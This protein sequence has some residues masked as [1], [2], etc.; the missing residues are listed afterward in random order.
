VSF[1]HGFALYSHLLVSSQRRRFVL[2]Q[3]ISAHHFH[4][5]TL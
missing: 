4:I 1:T 5:D 2:R 3:E